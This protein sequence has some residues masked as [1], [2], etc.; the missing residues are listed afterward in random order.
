MA[1]SFDDGPLIALE[2]ELESTCAAWAVVSA[3]W[4]KEPPG[5][6]RVE[7]GLEEERLTIRI[8]ELQ[9]AIAKAKPSTIAGAAVLL[10]RLAAQITEPEATNAGMLMRALAAIESHAPPAT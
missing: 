2:T 6:E 7:L 4:P 10:R 3:A 8:Q 9:D 1:R 5:M